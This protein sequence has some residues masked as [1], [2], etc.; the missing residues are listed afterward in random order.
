M[1]SLLRLRGLSAP[2]GRVYALSLSLS[3]GFFFVTLTSNATLEGRGA[4]CRVPLEAVVRGF[5][6]CAATHR[7]GTEPVAPFRALLTSTP[8]VVVTVPALVRCA[9]LLGWSREVATTSLATG[10]GLI[11]F[12][13]RHVASSLLPPWCSAVCVCTSGG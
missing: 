11:P 5:G 8:W 4:F 10:F 3:C 7:K 9:R 1:C 2:Q 12:G 6:G 13:R